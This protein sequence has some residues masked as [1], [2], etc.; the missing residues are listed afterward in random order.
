MATGSRHPCIQDVGLGT[1]H[2][3]L[4][5]TATLHIPGHTLTGVSPVMLTF[6]LDRCMPI[7]RMLLAVWYS[8]Q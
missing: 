5:M 7:V 8:T 4:Q 6:K 1:A 2:A 3:R